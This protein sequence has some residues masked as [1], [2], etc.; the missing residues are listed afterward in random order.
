GRPAGV[1][2]AAGPAVSLAMQKVAVGHDNPVKVR[3]PVSTRPGLLQTPLRSPSA[4]P[5]RSSATHL[6]AVAQEIATSPAA[7]SVAA[8][9][10]PAG[11]GDD[12]TAPLGAAA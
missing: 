10:Q 1:W 7:R 9:C 8:R 4:W 5:A 3:V 6:V 12:S 2:G 11:G